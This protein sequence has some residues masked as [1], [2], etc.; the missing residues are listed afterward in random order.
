M[1]AIPAIMLLLIAA[2]IYAILAF[3][4]E[5]SARLDDRLADLS[6]GGRDNLGW[7]ISQLNGE[8]NRLA[9]AAWEHAD[10]RPASDGDLRL[11]FDIFVSRVG[12]IEVGSIRRDLHDRDFYQSAV[13]A[14]RDFIARYDGPFSSRG[15]PGREVAAALVIDARALLPTLRELALGAAH[16]SFHELTLQRDAMREMRQTLRRSVMVLGLV[17]AGFFAIIAWLL[18]RATRVAAELREANLNLALKRERFLDAIETIPDAFSMYDADDRLVIC[19]ERY[20]QM[21]AADSGS[22]R[23]GAA[24]GEILREGVAQGRFPDAGGDVEAFVRKVLAWRATDSPAIDRPV[25]GGQWMRMF[26]RRTSDGGRVSIATDITA[27]KQAKERAESGERAKSEFLAAMSH[28]IRTPL[29]GV[30]GML[31]LIDITGLSPDGRRYIAAARTAGE[32]LVAVVN[33]ILDLSKLESGRPDFEIAPFSPARTIGQVVSIMAPRAAEEGNTLSVMG[34]ED[35]PPWLAGDRTRLRQILINLVGNATKFTSGGRIVINASAETRE[36]GVMLEIAVTDTGIGIP[37][38]VQSRLFETFSQ[39]DSSTTRR[40]GGTGLGLAICKRLVE[41]QGGSIG[42][43]SK[44]G[45]GARFWFRIPFAFAVPPLKRRSPAPENQRSLDILVAEDNPINRELIEA[46]LRAAGHRCTLVA[47]GRAAVA[48]VQADRYDIVLMDV[49]MPVLNGLCAA[50]EIRRLDT[51]VSAIPIVALT[52]DAFAD[53]V[54]ACLD[55]GM[56]DHVAKPIDPS[57]LRRA[58]ARWGGSR[59]VPPHGA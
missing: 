16:F 3:E 7:A 55:A 22:I 35:L 54:K 38:A 53:Q 19:N 33:D 28:E 9:E 5:T 56:N 50:R 40:F 30:L 31:G 44:P 1:L 45:R 29:N 32:H 10:G 36:D 51:P 12:T 2:A 52:A 20:R 6:A 18:M 42:I 4:Q 8:L 11:R 49:Q 39:A 14:L 58:L 13:T 15:G 34:T 37:P 25:S 48:A 26:T 46:L 41:L 43:E 27:L 47:D 17:A 57:R 21:Y 24:F 23:P 59:I